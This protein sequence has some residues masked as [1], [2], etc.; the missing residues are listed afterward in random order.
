MY[1]SELFPVLHWY[2][3]KW[4]V[5]VQFRL[6]LNA[7][8]HLISY[9]WNI[10]CF[11]LFMQSTNWMLLM[12]LDLDLDFSA[13]A[14]SSR[15]SLERPSNLWYV[16]SHRLWPFTSFH[17]GILLSNKWRQPSLRIFVLVLFSVPSFRYTCIVLCRGRMVKFSRW[18]SIVW[19]DQVS[20]CRNRQLVPVLCHVL[21]VLSS[22][23]L[24][25][26]AM[27]L[28]ASHCNS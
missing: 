14:R 1:V 19:V 22:L 17:Y 21:V 7:M 8:L 27:P 28:K 6:G 16:V 13:V 26:L 18:I 5:A 23:S 15:S 11:F 2:G 25:T 12:L 3:I 4:T 9:Q 10:G 24:A 20:I